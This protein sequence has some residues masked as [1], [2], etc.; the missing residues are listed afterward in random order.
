MDRVGPMCRTVTDAA[1]LLQA[2][3]RYDPKDSASLDAEV[4]DYSAVLRAKTSALRL[5]IPR[6]MFCQGLDPEIEASMNEALRVLRRLTRGLSE[7]ELPTVSDL[8]SII[9]NAEVY[10]FHAPHFL[11]HPKLYQ[12]LTRQEL[13]SGSRVTTPAYIQ[14]RRELDRIRRTI[15]NI[16][17]SV[18]LLVTP[19]TPILPITIEEAKNKPEDWRSIR[20]T[21]P[22]N[23]YGLPSISIPCGFGRSGLPVGLQI[24]G[25]Y[26]GEPQ[27][28]ALAYAYEQETDWHTRRPVSTKDVHPS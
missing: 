13:Q 5:G 23:I 25:P 15:G 28:L 12:P 20:N 2:I 18:D 17:S 11:K 3:A 16:F 24:C 14:A 6:A 4:P 10:A 21:S 22:F 1:L 26:L 27:I 7:V 9:I 8:P 19:T